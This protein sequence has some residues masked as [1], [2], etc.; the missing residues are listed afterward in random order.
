MFLKNTNLVSIIEK[1]EYIL[2]FKQINN[3]KSNLTIILYR[4]PS[5]VPEL[6]TQS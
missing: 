5:L 6:D 3:F 4:L 2:T 1:S